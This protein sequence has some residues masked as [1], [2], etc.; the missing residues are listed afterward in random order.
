MAPYIRKFQHLTASKRLLA[1]PFF[2]DFAQAA[3][4]AQRAGHVTRGQFVRACLCLGYEAP[5]AIL[6]QIAIKYGYSDN[7]F[8]DY[9][10]FCAVINPTVS[11]ASTMPFLNRPF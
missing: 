11:A 4:G 3:S 6:E 5:I 10:K 1:Q 9:F 8:V 2:D 7:E